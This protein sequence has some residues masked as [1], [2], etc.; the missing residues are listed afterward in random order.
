MVDGRPVDVLDEKGEKILVK[1]LTIRD[2]SEESVSRPA[3]RSLKLKPGTPWANA[4]PEQNLNFRRESAFYALQK[5]EELN[6]ETGQIE[7]IPQA[8][9][10]GRFKADDGLVGFIMK[11]A[12]ELSEEEAV[13]YADDSGL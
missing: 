13:L 12:N 5:W 4:S 8:S 1:R 10:P 6:D 9:W 7:D 11:K 2:A 3:F